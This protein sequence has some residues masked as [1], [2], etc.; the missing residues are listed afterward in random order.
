MTT[1]ISTATL[2]H[3]LATTRETL[4]LARNILER[5]EAGYA[6]R[7]TGTMPADRAGL[8]RR[9]RQHLAEYPAEEV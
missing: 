6:M 1:E 2:A 7:G 3:A 4:V 9:I 5:E 8:L